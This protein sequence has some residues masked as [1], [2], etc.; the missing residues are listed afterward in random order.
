M[1][2][3]KL[4]RSCERVLAAAGITL[5]GSGLAGTAVAEPIYLLYGH[6]GEVVEMDSDSK[7]FTD[8]GS[9]TETHTSNG[10]TF[11]LFYEDVRQATGAGFNGPNGTAARARVKDALDIISASLNETGTLDVLFNLSLNSGTSFLATAG[12]FYSTGGGFQGGTCQQRLLTGTKPFASSPEIQ[13]TVDFSFNWNFTTNAPTV[14]QVDFVS[15]ML[16]EFT[17]GLGI[18]SLSGPSGASLIPG[19]AQTKFSQLTRLGDPGT[20]LW[21]PAFSGTSAALKSNNLF[22]TGTQARANYNQSGVAP[23]VFAP[24][25]LNPGDD[26]RVPGGDGDGT[27][28][29]FIQGSSLSHFD[30]SNIV[31]GAV[32]EHSIIIG[33]QRRNYT[34]MEIGA[35]VDIGYVNTEDPNAVAEGE[36]EGATEGE[37][38]PVTVFVSAQSNLKEEGDNITFLANVTGAA[39]GYQW[40]KDNADIGGAVN[41]GLVKTNLQISDSGDYRVRVT[42][43]A[44]AVVTSPPFS[45]TVVPLGSLPVGSMFGLSALAAAVAIAGGSGLRRRR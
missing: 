25:A 22:F 44:K 19:G 11:N 3:G 42:T 17:H 33:T 36:G 38:D 24:S 34:A 41:P 20:A 9:P 29:G 26:P 15:V 18:A 31:G 32:M 37:P 28:D 5:L 6:T 45:L 2:R 39:L 27:P 43:A 16:H 30:T 7:A 13:T 35:L 40:T 12:T 21:N 14:S 4:G 1:M 10:I 8:F 23:G